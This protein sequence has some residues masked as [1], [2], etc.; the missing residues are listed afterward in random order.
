MTF[1]NSYRKSQNV[2]ADSISGNIVYMPPEAKDVSILMKQIIRE[3]NSNKFKDIPL[4]IRAGIFAYEIVTIHPF[5]DENEPLV[6][7]ATYPQ[8]AYK[9]GFSN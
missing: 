7:N 9:L 6:K 1:K 8:N 4:P 2:V 3:F 5:M